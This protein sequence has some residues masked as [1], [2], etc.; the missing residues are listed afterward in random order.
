MKAACCSAALLL[1]I[2]AVAPFLFAQTPDAAAGFIKAGDE[3]YARFDDASALIEYEK[4]AKAE[5]GNYEALW[6]T[7]RAYFDVGDRISPREK[8]S[9]D[10]M[11]KH[12]VISENY[13]RRAIKANPNDSWGHFFLSAAMG[14]RALL[15]SKKEQVAMSKQVKA[16]IDRAIELNPN[17]DLALHAL[18]HWHRTMA[19]IGGAKRFFGGLLYGDIPKGSFEESVKA[20]KRAIAINPNYGNHH[21]ELGRTYLDMRQ[22]DLAA[23]EFQAAVDA[24]L[25]TSKCEGYRAEAR[26]ELKKLKG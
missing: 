7:A 18:G 4:A 23:R 19:E 9:R 16:E 5:P 14:K 22:K 12:Y 6:K 13:A 10:R 3:L 2:F 17:N 26:E 24:P 25:T 8:D 1:L 15:L 21:L 11:I 20:Y